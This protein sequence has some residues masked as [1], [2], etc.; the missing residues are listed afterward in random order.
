MRRKVGSSSRSSR[1]CTRRQCDYL[2]P[3]F[4]PSGYTHSYYT[5]GVVY[6]GLEKIGVSWEDFRKEY[7]NQGGDGIY[8][9]WSVAYLEPVIAERKFVKRCPWVYDNIRYEKGLCPTAEKI[10]PKIMQFKT[11]YRDLMLAQKKAD[12]L[13]KTIKCFKK[14]L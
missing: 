7:I 8:G 13:A 6:E 9:A 5:L 4:I 10:Q 3:Q 14:G 11:N 1:I 12:C 2:I